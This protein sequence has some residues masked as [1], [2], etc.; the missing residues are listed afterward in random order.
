MLCCLTANSEM[1]S[2]GS[3]SFS[4]LKIHRNRTECRHWETN[5]P[6]PHTEDAF[7]WYS[8]WVPFNCRKQNNKNPKQ[9]RK[10]QQG[11]ASCL[12]EKTDTLPILKL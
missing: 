7:V 1:E 9:N 2:E 3:V 5:M 11:T 4:K 6:R 12:S 10:L 8:K